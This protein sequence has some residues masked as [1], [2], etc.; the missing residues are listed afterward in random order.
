[1]IKKDRSI[2]PR[3]NPIEQYER[4]SHF[5]EKLIIAAANIPN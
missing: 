5:F 2:L 3:E 4:Y 1:M